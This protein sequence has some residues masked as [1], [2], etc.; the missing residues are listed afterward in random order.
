[1]AGPVIET[2]NLTVYYGERRGIE[3]VSLT[4]HRGEVFGFLGPNGAGKT[5]TLR[6]LMDVIRPT[7]GR[8][9]LFGLDCR[10]DGVAARKRVGYLPG[11]LNLD[12][13]MKASAFLDLVAAVHGRRADGDYRQELC[14]RLDLNTTRKIGEYS[15]GNKQKVGIVAAFMIK[16]DLLVLDEPT[17]GLDPLIQQHVLEM[18][19]Q[20]RDEGRTVFFSSHILPEVQSVCDR[21]GIIR[22]GR[23]VV[24][25]HVAALTKQK[26]KRIQ[27]SLARVPPANAFALDG[28]R[29]TGR[30]GRKVT[31]EV[32]GEL[33]AAM[34]KACEYGVEDLDTLPVTLEEVF[35]T[36]Y[37][38]ESRPGDV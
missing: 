23:L 14:E 19:K 10:K 20:A 2:T 18:V 38:P 15:R 28:V 3:D 34:E 1:M 4:V 24:V 36:F 37:D 29:E 27:L 7:R 22:A 30:N 13:G 9:A 5:T 26:F 32:H 12:P 11:E 17:S 21:V 35:L 25:E 6:V 8:A 16:P 33:K 31:L